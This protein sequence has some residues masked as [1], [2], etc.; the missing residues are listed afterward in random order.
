MVNSANKTHKNNNPPR[1]HFDINSV[2]QTGP[3]WFQV[4]ELGQRP[5]LQMLQ[6]KRIGLP[7]GQI[8]HNMFIDHTHTSKLHQC[9]KQQGNLKE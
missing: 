6:V 7:A 4:A 1:I 5:H 8:P 9:T 3:T 2:Y